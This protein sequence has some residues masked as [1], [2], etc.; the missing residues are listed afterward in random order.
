MLMTCLDGQSL[1]LGE[2]LGQEVASTTWETKQIN[3]SLP[4][5]LY[6]R[7]FLG[8]SLRLAALKETLV[9]WAEVPEHAHQEPPSIACAGGV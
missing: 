1:S 8:E 4:M 2:V 7:A 9:L 3:S 5:S 6:L